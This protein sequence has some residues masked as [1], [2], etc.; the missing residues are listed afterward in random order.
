M[1]DYEPTRET[2]DVRN[3]LASHGLL[4]KN[5]G[6]HRFVSPTTLPIEVWTGANPLPTED[7]SILCDNKPVHIK[8]YALTLDELLARL[9]FG[10]TTRIDLHLLPDESPFW[11][12]RKWTNLGFTTADRRHKRFLRYVEIGRHLSEA[13]WDWRSI[14]MHVGT[15]VRW[16]YAYNVDSRGG[17][18]AFVG[19]METIGAEKTLLLLEEAMTGL[20]S[21]LDSDVDN[22]DAYHW[23]LH[24]HP[25]LLDVYG[26]VTSK[27]R[28]HYPAGQVS[29]IGKTYLEPDFIVTYPDQTYRLIELERPGKRLDTVQGQ[30]RADLTQAAFQIGEWR[31]FIAHHPNQIQRGIPRPR[32]NELSNGHHSWEG[33]FDSERPGSRALPECRKGNA[34]RRRG[35]DVRQPS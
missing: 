6:V 10:I 3:F 5:I 4:G 14:H 11:I 31:D 35:V 34:E 28:F 29:A 1:I 15:D 21:M 26:R 18:M 8:R 13:A 2:D 20:T 17:G 9:T 25:I 30:P 32:V 7:R 19:A 12:T 16:D 22:E 23:Y 27:P 24:E 33:S